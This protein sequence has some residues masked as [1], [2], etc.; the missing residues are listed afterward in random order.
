[1]R[2]WPEEQLVSPQLGVSMKDI[3]SQV[4]EQRNSLL[5]RL[6]TQVCLVTFCKNVSVCHIHV[7]WL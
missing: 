2:T 6:R 5:D 4:A 7:C 3:N 1:M